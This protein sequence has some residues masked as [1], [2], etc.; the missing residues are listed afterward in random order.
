MRCGTG[1]T[2]AGSL[3]AGR[4]T[5]PAGVGSALRQLLARSEIHETRAMVAASDALATFRTITLPAA[6]PDSN[7][8][9]VVA[10]ELPLDKDR[11][12]TR[13]FDVHTNGL[14]RVVFATA[15]DRSQV[16]GVVDAVKAAGLEPAVVDLK[17]ACLAR[18]V[19]P[20]AA[21]VVDMSSTPTEI[22]LIDSHLPQ[23][24]RQVDLGGT[25]PDENLA[26]LIEPVRAVV[27]YAGRGKSSDFGPDSPVLVAADQTPSP[28]AMASASAALRR[29]VDLLPL[30]PRVPDIRY[31]TYLACLGLLMRRS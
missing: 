1:G 26:A 30:P 8:E 24:S 6:T 5:D 9:S 12:A 13:W 19:T 25:S 14:S 2:P 4:V 21:V 10:K 27:R 3:V 29:P 23:L 28:A 7:V 22:V 31:A 15:W 16:K 18:T 11:T 17:S 20:S